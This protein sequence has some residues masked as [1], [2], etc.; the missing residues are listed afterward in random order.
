GDGKILEVEQHDHSSL[1]FG[2]RMD[3]IDEVDV[4]D[5]ILDLTWLVP[6]EHCSDLLSPCR[7]YG[8]PD[9]D[10][11]YPGPWALVLGDAPPTGEQLDEGVLGQ[12]LSPPSIPEDQ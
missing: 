8:H 10:P 6:L 9:R 3:R 5:G 4:R 7:S 2:K 12:L 1:G 11:A